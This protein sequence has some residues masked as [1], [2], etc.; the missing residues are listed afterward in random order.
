MNEYL[1]SIV[2]SVLPIAELRGGIPYAL[3]NGIDPFGAYFLCVGANIMAFPITF[4]FVE[5]FHK[6]LIK[7]G[8]YKR[9]F[10]TFVTR[11]RNKLGDSVEMRGFW[12]L[13]IFVMIPLPVTGAY[14]GS[15]A[16]WLFGI[17]KKKAFLAVLLGVMIAGVIMTVGYIF[18]REGLSWMFKD[19]THFG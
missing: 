18:F 12:A 6:Y 2:I 11:T 7:W 15:F 19:P 3:Y 5:I 4:F 17:E 14:T 10:D 13:M 1:W 9:L 8:F 16:A